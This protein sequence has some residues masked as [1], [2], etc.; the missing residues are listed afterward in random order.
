MSKTV[1][2]LGGSGYIGK[3]CIYKL[4][5]NSSANVFSVSRS[6]KIDMSQYNL[7]QEEK[8]RLKVFKAS[9]LSKDDLKPILSQC[10]GVIHSIGTL[11]TFD[12]NGPNSYDT[13]GRQ[14]ALIAAEVLKENSGI[15]NFVYISAQRGLPFPLSIL[16]GDYIKSKRKAEEELKSMKHLNTTILLPGVVCDPK[17][18]SWSIPLYHSV[19]ILNS[20]EKTVLGKIS[21]Q[22]G[23]K[24]NLPSRGTML[25]N[26]ANYAAK[27]A[28]GELDKNIYS[29]DEMI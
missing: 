11:V 20:F 10:N 18:R 7:S 27:G 17:I 3:H 22:I 15:T 2:V 16:F 26:L 8:D 9:A 21:P 12:K 5:K 28:L 6:G 13:L 29:A 25:D 1:S 23:D 19:N 4:L 14:T 24:L